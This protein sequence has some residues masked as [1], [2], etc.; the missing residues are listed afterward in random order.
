MERKMAF[1]GVLAIMLANAAIADIPSNPNYTSYVEPSVIQHN[2]SG[3]DRVYRQN[4]SKFIDYLTPNG[5]KILLVATDGMSDEQL[6]RA[7]NILD[8]YLTDVPGSEFGSDKTAVANAMAD[9]GAVL[10]MPGGADGDSPI[11]ESAL[12]G[13]PLYALEFPIE[14]SPAYINND[15]EQRDAGFEEI[16]HMVHDYG[17]G[18]KYTPGPLQST[19]QAEIAKATADALEHSRWGIGDRGVKSWISELADEGSLEQEY[20]ASVL[21]SYYGYWG[22]WIEGDGGTWDIYVAK[23]RADVKLQD[24]MGAA[25]VPQFLSDT[26]TYMARIDPTFTGA[27]DMNFDADKPYTYKSQYLVNARL[28]GDQPSAIYGNDHDNVLVGNAADN[29]LDGKGGNDVVQYNATSSDAKINRSNSGLQITAPG[30]GT[31]TLID[32]ETLR[33]T[34]RDIATSSPQ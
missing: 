5:G 33:F 9:N 1:T 34:D 15:Y 28:L 6:L 19:Y 25:L 13:Q 10:V 17:I 7:Y 20:I 12:A 4:Y 26:V 24:P 16:F 32:I 3:L 8:F 18:T 30:H 31:D 23:T 29:V 21:D 11:D 2:L 27:F 14:G 22:A